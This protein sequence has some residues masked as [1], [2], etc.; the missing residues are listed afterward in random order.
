MHTTIVWFLC[1][2][3]GHNAILSLLSLI[4]YGGQQVGFAE[5]TLTSTSSYD[6]IVK[7]I[8]LMLC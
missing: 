4:F 1:Y 3:V 5:K 2:L 6:L 7:Y 8:L